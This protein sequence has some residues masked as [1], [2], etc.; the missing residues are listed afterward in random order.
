MENEIS[1]EDRLI[2]NNNKLVA[3]KIRKILLNIRNIAGISEKRWIWEMI[4][5]AKDVPNNFGKVDIK[6]ELNKNSFIFSHNGSYFRIKDVL[7]ILQQVSSKE[8]KNDNANAETTGKFGTGFI[9]THL[10]STIV[11]IKG[12]VKYRGL[13][14]KFEL[15]LDRS[16]DSSEELLKEV[17]KSIIEFKNNMNNENSKYEIK[18]TYNQKQTD[19]DTIFEYYLKDEESIRIAKEGISDLINTA[20]ITLASQYKKISSIS[21]KNDIDNEE[22]E[23]TISCSKKTNNKE[24]NIFLN[25]AKI[26]SNKHKEIKL[27]F[28]SYESKD[29]RLLYQ[30]QK[31]E[32]GYSVVERKKD[33]PVLLRDFPLIGSENFHFPFFLDGFKFDPLETRNGL[34]LNGNIN[35]E[36]KNNREIIEKAVESSINFTKYLLEQNINK[37]YLLAKSNIPEPPQKYDKC[38]ID[39]FISLQKKWRKELLNFNL[40]KDEEE[41][42]SELKSLKLPQFKGKFNKKFY[43]LMKGMDNMINGVLPNEDDIELW[44]DIMEKDPLKEVYNIKENTWDF[45]YLITEEDLFKK[46]EEYPT[47]EKFYEPSGK[48]YGE[49]LEWLNELYK[50]LDENHSKDYLNKYK[51]IP[52]QKGIFKKADEIFGNNDDDKNKIPDI[53]NEI[54][55]N[56]FGIEIYDIIVN[57]DIKLDNLGSIVKDKNLNHIFNEFSNFF[58]EEG[59]NIEKKKYLCNVFISFDVNNNNIKKM[60]K[61]RKDIEE[62]YK[63]ERLEKLGYYCDDHH[64]WKCVEEF[65]FNDHYIIVEKIQNIKNLSQILCDNEEKAYEWINNYIKFLKNNNSSTENKKIFPDQNGNFK[66]LA[67]LHYDSK[68]PEILKDHLNELRRLKDPKYDIRDSLLSNKIDSFINYNRMSQKEIISD[69]EEIFN[70]TKDDKEIKITISEKILSILPKNETERFNNI[71]NA[72][73]ELILYYNIIYDRNIIQKEEDVIIE[74]NYRI[75]VTFI[76]DKVFYK[77]ERM[78]SNELSSKSEV[79]A[80]LI[81]FVWDNQNNKDFYVSIAP[82]NYRIFIN[83]NYKPMLLSNIKIKK[84]YYEKLKYSDLEN[85]LFELSKSKIVNKDYKDIFLEFSFD[86]ILG[87]KYAKKFNYINLDDMCKPIDERISNY[88]NYKYDI[89]LNDEKNKEYKKIFFELNDILK[90]NTQLKSYF[91]KFMRERGGIAIKF[92]SKNEEMDKFIEDIGKNRIQI[93]N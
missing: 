9:G 93:I 83:Q 3:D 25:T 51:M 47:I 6:I 78:D 85:K 80:K 26:T 57:Q 71:K 59:S 11:K 2:Y 29:C 64:I 41:S 37:R 15:L 33:Q 69:I 34:F 52:N 88:L 73:K 7:G 54:Y 67:D 17:D 38:A 58:K 55:K 42:Y 14:R 86:K 92:L 24:N 65:W 82:E 89:D 32:N 68:I 43:Y 21:I 4:Q 45:P 19:F 56:I 36:A 44:Y 8:S 40:V 74:S 5:N 23:Y 53:M 76:L 61:F 50:F 48:K 46:I 28:F 90:N 91:E 31:T 77:I 84:Y 1:I 79:I 10:L 35:N 60:F 22:C 70:T 30:V 81:K 13:F 87:E 20:P 12:I 49:I 18:S 16:A 63:N 75:F 27:Y 39:W 62:K 72:L 66:N